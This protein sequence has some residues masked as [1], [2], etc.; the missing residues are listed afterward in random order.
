MAC[1]P[2]LLLDSEV[3]SFATKACP[4]GQW[5]PGQWPLGTCGG[6]FDPA[7]CVLGGDKIPLHQEVP[8]VDLGDGRVACS[9]LLWS[10]VREG[11][12]FATKALAAAS[13]PDFLLL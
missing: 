2:F 11:K 13:A 9:P 6:L 1:S 3:K 12:S 10:F 4:C 7:F 8:A 5:L